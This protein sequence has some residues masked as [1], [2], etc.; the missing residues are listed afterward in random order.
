MK[1][2][3]HDFQHTTGNQDTGAGF[4]DR[5]THN[6]A[7]Q[8]VRTATG[9]PVIPS[10][11]IPSERANQGTEYHMGIHHIGNHNAFA[12]RR[13]DRQSKNKISNEIEERSKN[14]RLSWA[15]IRQWTRS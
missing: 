7:H 9:N 8:R 4:G 3:R 6:T 14:D 13:S 5:G 15:A 12:N 1:D 11:D 10:N 2:E